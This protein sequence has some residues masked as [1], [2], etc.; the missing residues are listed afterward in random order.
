MFAR[1]TIVLARRPGVLVIPRQA[2]VETE[3]KT[4]VF[5]IADGVAKERPV[6]LGVVEGDRVEVREGLSTGEQVAI[7]GHRELQDGAR[8]TVTTEGAR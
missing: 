6:T 4:V 1:A 3:G 2:T 7:E 8:V 5:V